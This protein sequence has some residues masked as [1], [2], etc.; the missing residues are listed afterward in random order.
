MS[1]KRT[2]LVT[3]LWSMGESWGLRIVSA[4][5][6]LLL[7][8]LIEPAAF[9]LAALAQVYLM[10]VQ[11]LSDQGLTTALIQRETI[12]EAHKNSAFWANL[13][14]GLALM[15]LTIL[16]AGPLAGLY[17]EP[18]LAP[19]LQ[20]YS[21]APFLTSISVVQVGLARR[22]LRFRELALRQTAGAVVGGAV[23]IAMAFAGMGV[24]ALVG[25]GLV[26]QAVGVVI[27]WA[28]VDWRPRLVFSRRHFRDL[29]G[30]GFSV[31]VTNLLRIFG[32]QADRLLLGFY[33]G[34]AEVGYY[35]VAQRLV[36]I[37]TDFVAGSTERAVV[38]LFSRIQGDRARVARGLITAQR[39]L[40]LTVIPAFVGLAAV[41]PSLIRVAV[42]DQ[43][44]PS[45]L[46]TRILAFFSLAYC[47]GFFFGQVVT[48]LGRPTIRLGVVLAQSLAQA[49]SCLIGV[50][51]GIPGVAVAMAVTQIVFYGVELAVLRRMVRFSVPSYLAE[52]LVPA[53]AATA[54]AAAVLGIDHAL[55]GQRA[56]LQVVAEIVAGALVYGALLLLFARGRIRELVGLF[57]G[58]RG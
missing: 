30:F 20:W 50:A 55:A 17:G 23:G 29:F 4:G 44:M 42:G 31:L 14:V 38:P 54:M 49:G 16:F 48:A 5:V 13:A 9:G 24:W 2:A 8:R 7:A 40:S 34:A 21:L 35:S 22:E 33:F 27:L 12:E 11:T 39:L 57:R 32:G 36:T 28:I 1:M 58:L 43:W 51:W 26:T 56:A 41:A 37:I 3:A 47:L 52:A 19:V 45:I 53:L 18:R 10:A 46:P 6:F 25:Q 15:G